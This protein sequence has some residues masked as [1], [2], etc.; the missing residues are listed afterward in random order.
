MAKYR[1]FSDDHQPTIARKMIA[2]EAISKKKLTI[3]F[4]HAHDANAP[5]KLTQLLIVLAIQTRKKMPFASA[6]DSNCIKYPPNRPSIF[7]FENSKLQ[8]HWQTPKKL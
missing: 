8:I 2:N 1:N 6:Y 4:V 7:V 5:L 3:E